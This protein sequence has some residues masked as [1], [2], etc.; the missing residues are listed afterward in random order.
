[1][2]RRFRFDDGGRTAA[3]YRGKAGDCVVRAI[4]IATERPYQEIYE[5]VNR[6]ATRERTGKRKRGISNARTGVYKGSIHRVM[7]ELGWEWTPTMQIGSGCKVHLRADELPAGRLV[8]S[9]SKHLTAMVD[10]VIY[11]THDCSRRGTRCVYGFWSEGARARAMKRDARYA[12]ADQEQ[13]RSATFGQPVR[14]ESAKPRR[15]VRRVPRRDEEQ[16]K[17]RQRSFWEWLFG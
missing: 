10:G 15:V 13:E 17:P 7:K 4:A 5:L 3:G 2:P 16:E 1:L 11:D 12:V 14:S 8:V 6:A 9:V